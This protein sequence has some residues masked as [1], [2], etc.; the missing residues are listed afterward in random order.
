MILNNNYCIFNEDIIIELQ[1][2][3]N[4]FQNIDAPNAWITFTVTHIINRGNSLILYISFKCCIIFLIEDII[5]IVWS[6]NKYN[7]ELTI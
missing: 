6:P 1:W 2:F 3:H 7:N 4:F 5:K